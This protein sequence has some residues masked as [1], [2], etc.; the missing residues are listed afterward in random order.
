MTRIYN[1]NVYQGEE[2]T[3]REKNRQ[4]KNSDLGKT[5]GE[6]CYFYLLI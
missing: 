6:E 5:Q 2:D 1:L 3:I 4:E